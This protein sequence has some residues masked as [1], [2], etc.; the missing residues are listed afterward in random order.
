MSQGEPGWHEP[1]SA[2]LAAD[3]SCCRRCRGKRS[4]ASVHGR[5]L[6]DAAAAL[7]AGCRG[8]KAAR[9]PQPTKRVVLGNARAAGVLREEVV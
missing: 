4:E 5:K 8:G 6:S 9:L 3:S 2:G 7:V 1:Q